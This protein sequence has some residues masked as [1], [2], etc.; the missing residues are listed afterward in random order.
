MQ[1][2]A[3]TRLGPYEIQA[4]IGTGGMGEVYRA[5]DTRLDRTV[6]V[7][8]LPPALASDPQFRDRFGREARAISALDHPHV[9]ALYDV[10]EENGCSFLV[11]QHLEGETLADRIAR[12]AR[13]SV[14]EALTIGIQIADA[15]DAAHRRGIVHRDLK[16]GNVMMTRS[17][18]RLLDFGLAKAQAPAGM[19]ASLAATSPAPITAHGAVVGTLAYMSPEQVEG[20]EADARSDVWAFGCVLY[21]ML[22]GVRPFGGASAGSVIGSIMR[23]TPPPVSRAIPISP[24]ALD[25]LVAKCLAKD[26]DARWQTASDLRD[27]MQWIAGSAVDT[28]VRA[29]PRSRRRIAAGIAGAALVFAGIA[30]SLVWIRAGEDRAAAR[31]TRLSIA[32]P[33]DISFAGS[34]VVSPDGTRMAFVA[35]REGRQTLWIRELGDLTPRALPG[36]DGASLPFWSPD[37]R[38]IGFFAH[39]RLK[40]I[41]ADG[42]ALQTIADAINGRGGTWNRDGVILFAPV[43]T[44]G[45]HRVPAR[46]GEPVAVTRLDPRRQENSHR[47][48]EFLPDGRRFVFRVRS[49]TRGNSGA[50]IASLDDP[51]HRFLLAADS[52]VVPAP[53]HL[54]FARDSTLFAQPYDERTL[55]LTG[56]PSAVASDAGYDVTTSQGG[57]SASSTGILAY[58][59]GSGEADMAHQLTWFDRAGRQLGIVAEPGLPFNPALSPNGR[60]LAFDRV[61]PQTGARNVW[62]ADL[63]RNVTSRL[64][65]STAVDAAPV[66]SPDGTRIVFNSSREGPQHLYVKA[67]GA[68]G[69]EHKIGEFSSFANPS[70]W[71]P[72]GRIIAIQ[73]VSPATRSD[74]WI[75]TLGA[76][77]ELRPL[78]ATPFDERQPRFSPDGRWIA[79]TSDE[80]DRPEVYVQSF[81][82]GRAR[83]RVSVSGGT[84]PQWRGDGR[85]LFFIS[86]DERL[87]S[88]AITLGVDSVA[89]GLPQ[90]LFAVRIMAFAQNRNDYVPDATGQRF[91]V[92]MRG[93]RRVS[94]PVV[95]VQNWLAALTK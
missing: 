17:G 61:M 39:G 2:V 84:Q 81:P 31:V 78:L 44:E 24:P 28:P 36:T 22:T 71:S 3:G 92:S 80:S 87:M 64:T 5:R 7:K 47:F 25:R 34:P 4:V 94:A 58:Y 63:E 79:Y 29:T 86:A 65:F 40:R 93:E 57:F 38:S 85:E 30:G 52:S 77:N 18:A 20:A 21:E 49:G 26:P 76:K 13:V 10:G 55:Q 1:L 14:A 48:P 51:A 60:Y 72:D 23:D 74:L 9:C 11:M 8:V 45:L 37:S 62:V 41:D 67:I 16:P 32:L 35:A 19:G 69:A 95:V 46:G 6:A 15:L 82:E 12:T 75:L 33:P 88:A 56:E 54:L 53:G 91:L 43:V 90:P 42:S 70:S 59:A 68:Q 73:R 50:Y 66:W 27:E 83:V 89:A